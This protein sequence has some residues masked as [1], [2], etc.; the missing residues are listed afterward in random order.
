MDK[1]IAKKMVLLGWGSA[2]WRMIDPIIE[3][4]LMP[5][6][7]Q[8]ISKV[9]KGKIVG[10]DP[11]LPTSNWTSIVT[12]KNNYH[13]RSW[14]CLNIEKETFYPIGVK[15]RKSKAIWNILSESGIKA[16]QIGCIASHPAE[17]LKNGISISEYFPVSSHNTVSPDSKLELFQSLRVIKSQITNEQLKDF[18]PTI[19]QLPEQEL[20]S[21]KVELIKDFI[22]QVQSIQNAAEYIL[23]NEEW[24]FV[25][26]FFNQ[27][28]WLTYQFAS[29]HVSEGVN[30]D[31]QLFSAFKNVV[32]AA[33]SLLDKYLGITLELLDHTHH[34]FIVSE[35]GF[36]PNENWIKEIKRN[37]TSKEYN[38]EGIHV[39]KGRQ[40]SSHSKVL[41]ATL[42]DIVPTI[43]S[44]FGLP[45]SKE[46]EASNILIA[47][48]YFKG[49]LDPIHTWG[50]MDEN[51]K[52]VSESSDE[53]AINMGLDFLRRVEY[54]DE[55]TKIQDIKDRHAYFNARTQISVGQQ[56]MA[57][58]ILESLWKENPKN[59]WYGGR[60]AG[61]YFV[62]NQIDEGLRLLDY[63]LE[64]GEEIPDL[65]LMKAN[66]YIIEKKYRSASR[67]MEIAGKNPNDLPNIYSSIA[68]LYIQIHQ[69]GLA[70]KYYKLEIKLH[71]TAE[72]HFKIAGFYMQNKQFS[73]P[74]PHFEAVIEDI[75]NHPTALMHLGNCLFKSKEYE[76]AAEILEKAKEVALDEKA[77]KE[78]QGLLVNIYR[79]QLK[80]PEKLQEMQK[81]FE[82]SIGKFGTITIVSGLPRSGTSMLMQMLSEGGMEVFTD[83]KREADDNNQK[84]YYEHDAVKNMAKSKRF[85]AKVGPK[86][87]KIISHL[88]HHLPHI[89][90]YKIV[91]M[92]REIEEVMHSQ[93]KML[94]RL[95]KDRG[96]DKENS[97][98]LLEPFQ[99]SRQQAINWCKQ[100]EKYVDLLLIP[101]HDVVNNPLEQAEKINEFLGGKLDVKKM[102][103]VVDP[104][105]YREKV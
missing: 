31:R 88:L 67:E 95:G 3:Q 21:S 1:R 45:I 79:F 100:K 56:L 16:H 65:H 6:L 12:G 41:N 2:D 84:G 36:K 30:G 40:Y 43:T 46:F 73:K 97:L 83:G 29:F 54:L 98:K 89:Y 18:V 34:L 96:A 104:T 51:I 26:V 94:G 82:D 15:D 20:Y 59:S 87:V 8:L 4:G 103:S 47:Q 70:E 53:A 61:C 62:K 71:P 63:V 38:T 17:K 55:D 7:K 50:T 80:K 57:I 78:I 74:I 35:G 86:A 90:K 5:N 92:D 76:K 11:P 24:E 48:R 60:L 52:S 66:Y 85:L 32:P 13:H 58:P 14:K 22:A 99:K 27:M 69:H 81:Q 64:L 91:F 42:F 72:K 19:D 9:S 77:L 93:H 37:S 102:A 33:Y 39:L 49:K 68:D 44:L 75:P 105:L 28:M 23:K 101:Y 10:S 25:A